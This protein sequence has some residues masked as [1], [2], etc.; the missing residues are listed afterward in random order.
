MKT[1]KAITSTILLSLLL[2]SCNK[3]E[4]APN[5]ADQEFTVQENSPSGTLIGAVEA[6]DQDEG[7]IVS[8]E[9]IDGNS[10]AIFKINPGTGILSVDDPSELDF[11]TSTELFLKI[12]AS[13]S[14]EKDPRESSASVKVNITDENEYA[15]VVKALVL[16]LNENPSVDQ[17]LGVVEATDQDS[18]QALSY[19]IKTQEAS[20]YVEIDAS[21]GSLSVLDSSIF[22]FESMK[23][24]VFEVE[25]KDD[26][27]NYKS[28]VGSV[29]INLLD[30]LELTEEMLAHYPFDGN[31]NNIVDDNFQGTVY[32]AQAVNDMNGNP[33]SAFSFDGIEDY[34]ALG[35]DFDFQEKTISFRFNANSVPV[36][37]YENN[38]I[39][40][41]S[42]LFV[43][44]HPG[45]NHGA[46]RISVS[47]VDGTP[48]IWVWKVNR[49]FTPDP[50]FLFAPI[51]T[52]Q[53]YHVSVLISQDSLSL[54]LDGDLIEK[55]ES[56]T[57]ETSDVGDPEAIV[58]RGRTNGIRYFDG[59]V[60]EVIIHSR[61]LEEHEI[62]KLSEMK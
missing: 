54:Y 10:D 14:H 29:T 47:N 26:H 60:D 1:L 3:N 41:L 36:F 42:S 6:I 24:L 2:F 38:P 57:N 31:A 17:V 40:S 44:N 27:A 61:L 25:V 32:G 8:F 21:T 46:Q 19:S 12:S 39:G 23:Q 58:G 37:D 30:V 35:S 53:W 5:I 50:T 59:A 16:E 56:S 52:A 34:I 55:V 13:D 7:Q 28:V 62:K 18:H 48:R 51:E 15:P 20:N 45:L 49:S 4:N 9:I 33:N 22:D 11:E 43:V